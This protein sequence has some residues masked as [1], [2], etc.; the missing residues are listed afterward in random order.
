MLAPR[1]QRCFPQRAARAQERQRLVLNA[2]FA[3]LVL[4][5]IGA[6]CGLGGERFALRIVYLLSA[7]ASGIAAIAALAFL[8]GDGAPVEATL[9]VGLPWL[10]A[11]F[12]LDALSAAFLLILDVVAALVSVFAHGYGSHDAEPKRILPLYPIFL[13]AMNLVLLANDAYSFLVSWELMSLSSWLLVL[14]NHRDRQTGH[15]AAV[16]LVMASFGTIAL[17]LAFGVLA[18]IGGDYSF[19]A[20]RHTAPGIL[21][22]SI[23]FGLVLLGAGSKAGLVPLHAWLPLAHPAAPSH[24]SALMSGVMT[25]V[26]I[27]ALIRVLFDL[28]GSPIWWWGGIILLLGAASAL[29]GVLYAVMQSDLKTLLAYSTVENVGIITIGIGLALAFKANGLT[30]LAGLALIA[31]LL[32]VFNHA[33][34][35]S[36]LFLGSGAVLVATGQRDIERLGGLIHR[37]PVTA[38]AFL[39]GAAAI[40][41]LPPL[42]GFASE[43]LVFQAILNGTVLPQWLLKLALPIVGLM[44]ALAAA[45]AAVCFV[46]AYGIVFL[47]R[48]RGTQAAAAEEAPAVMR[49]PL[50]VLAGLCVVFG[51][52]PGALIDLLLPA[53]RQL[54]GP[55]AL[56]FARSTG[57]WLVPLRAEQSSYSGL[58]V[59]LAIAGLIGL[60]VWVIH[61]FA[62]ARVRRAPAWDC[63]FPDPRP[64]LQ[65]TGSS[66]AQPIRRVFGTTVFRARETL[67]MP[68]PGETRPAHFAV[69]LRDLVWDGFYQPVIRL[70]GWLTE[71]IDALQFLTIRR[72]L[73]LTF[74]SL[75]LLLTIVAVWQ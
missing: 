12:R 28:V 5:L 52:V 4:H 17:L 16:Y 36:L 73:T 26:A 3:A 40:S 1:W 50:A 21:P 37:M 48:P 59:F 23:V 6:A 64:Q 14:A 33:L 22:A 68:E 32:H 35:K 74:A 38:A 44:L 29:L 10:P 34:F 57:L 45:L 47:G 18:G 27:Y 71:H 39:V 70:V 43:W 75:V 53:M 61:R 65:Y 41:A 20:I 42:N 63:G 54:L 49:I 30:T 56:P 60:L 11:H 24:V 67:D 9:P 72:Y 66:F 31:A 62:S 15:A 46:R 69:T 7:A 55:D 13:A 58:I 8:L 51:I 2:I 19:A 25:K